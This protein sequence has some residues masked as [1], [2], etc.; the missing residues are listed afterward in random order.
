MVNCGTLC[1]R[2][3]IRD[4]ERFLKIFARNENGTMTIFACFMILMMLMVGGIGVDLM[5]N[6]MERTRLQAVSDRAVLA[7]A[8]LDQTLDPEAVVRD[9]FVK[10]G[11]GDYVSNVTVVEGLNF[12][13]VNVDATTTMNTQFMN[14]VGVDTLVVPAASQAQ[15][16]VNKVEIS[17]VLDVS[18][19]MKNGT[20]M[21]DMQAAAGEFIDEVL[22]PKNR[23]LVSVSLIPY[24][25][26][27]N[28][29]PKIYDQMPNIVTT[30]DYSHCVEFTDA[31]FQTANFE[32]NKTYAQM[33]HYQWNW[34]SI[35]S[36][37]QLNTVYDTVCPRNDYEEI[38][39][40]SQNASQ[41]KAQINAM[42]PRAGTQIFI[43]MKWAASMLDPSFRSMTADLSTAGH[44]DAAFSD[45]PAA[46]TDDETL[47]TVVLMTDG[48]NSKANR[49]YDAYYT[50]NDADIGTPRHYTHW[51]EYNLQYYLWNNV[52][53]SNHTQYYYNKYT[54]AK[55]DALLKNICDAAKA[56]EIIVWTIGFEVLDHGAT[57]MEDCASSPS[58][59]FRVAG[60][61]Q[62]K[63][64]FGAIAG[65]I[66]QL[67]LTQ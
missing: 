65:Q 61:E 28:A 24:S 52:S 4:E 13:T 67:R 6:E 11:M 32:R 37:S 21:A 29:G 3:R 50:T 59:F 17:L 53:S 54:E 2:D 34:Y 51:E 55:G 22:K 43:G 35:E 41:L 39:P 48:Q 7:A 25:Q 20:K 10:S 38:R 57:V 60:S 63:E 36:G 12:R 44:V 66:N 5:R 45:R 33:Q 58:H 9:Y 23:D 1:H 18:G 19:S 47:K 64:A 40:F 46:Y 31:D 8:D 42:K 49:I 26:H 30:H 56:R 14:M 62:I 16:K 15:E 27:V